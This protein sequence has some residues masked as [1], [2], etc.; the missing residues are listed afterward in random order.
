MDVEDGDREKR[1]YRKFFYEVW[2]KKIIVVRGGIF[3]KVEIFSIVDGWLFFR[4]YGKRE[5]RK[6]NVDL[7]FLRSS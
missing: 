2:R 6:K 3:R 5:G 4:G 1:K 7:E